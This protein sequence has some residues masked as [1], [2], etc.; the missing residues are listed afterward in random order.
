MSW[1]FESA[2]CVLRLHWNGVAFELRLRK[3]ILCTTLRL[4]RCDFRVATENLHV[5]YFAG[6]ESEPELQA[7]LSGRAANNELPL[8]SDGAVPIVLTPPTYS[9]AWF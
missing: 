7:L 4:K 3:C 1:V 2:L 8:R 9:K 6:T 5:E